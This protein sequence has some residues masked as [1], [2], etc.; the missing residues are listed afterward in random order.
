MRKQLAAATV[1]VAMLAAVVPSV[2][3]AT[4]WTAPLGSYGVASIR[5]GSPDRLSISAKNFRPR[6]AY[7]ITLRRGS[8]ATAGTLVYLTRLTSS[9]TGMLVRTLYLSSVQTRAV[10]LPLSIRIGTKCGAFAVPAPAQTPT[11]SPTPTPTPTGTPTPTPSAGGTLIVGPYFFLAIPAGWRD[12]TIGDA[13]QAHGPAVY[14]SIGT[15]TTTQSGLTLDAA[16]AQI[17]QNIKSKSGGADPEQN[18]AIT[19][20]GEPG[21]LLTY[22]F[23]T[24]GLNVYELEAHCVHNGRGYE[25]TFANLAGTENADRA[26]FLSILATFTFLSAG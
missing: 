8:C 10:K 17:I 23:V 5:V 9:S 26:L 3:A 24:Q 21:R 6:I 13:I 11:P 2:T 4:T 14:Q 12:T 16:T 15:D 1:A 18:E 19:L 25:I 20:G 22:H 7:P